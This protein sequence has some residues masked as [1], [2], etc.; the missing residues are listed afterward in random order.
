MSP[1]ASVTSQ[2]VPQPLILAASSPSPSGMSR[3]NSNESYKRDSA[4]GIGGFVQRVSEL[5]RG[6]RPTSVSE[7]EVMAPVYRLV[8]CSIF[9]DLAYLHHV[10]Y[11]IARADVLAHIALF[12]PAHA[13]SSA[14]ASTAAIP[15]MALL[16]PYRRGIQYILKPFTSGLFLASCFPLF[17]AALRNP[18]HGTI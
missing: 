18:R 4:V 17:L 13:I 14:V 11:K 7:S 3:S 10:L 15:T 9:P 2:V 1:R 5:K 8:C 16:I 6:R 12:N